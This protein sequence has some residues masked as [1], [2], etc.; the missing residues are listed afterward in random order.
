MQWQKLGL[1]WAPGGEADWA[2]SHATLPVVQ[3]QP[4]NR[5]WIY[6]STR[7]AHG[8][9]RIGRLMVDATS[10]AAGQPPAVLALDPTPVLSLGEPGTFDDSGVMP[11]WLVEYGDELHL[12]YVGW[13]VLATVPYR[14]AI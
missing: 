5:W 4:D 7:D 8:K 12:Y 1:I 2:C 9:S 13:N 6:I 14:Q 11:S 3:V 10:L